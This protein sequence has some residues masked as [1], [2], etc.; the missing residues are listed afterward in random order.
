VAREVGMRVLT[1]GRVVDV[2]DDGRAP[3]FLCNWLVR[4]L[5]N[6]PEPDSIDDMY[7]YVD[8]G[9]RVRSLDGSLDH[10]SCDAGHTRHSYGTLENERDN[11]AA[12][13]ETL[14]D[15]GFHAD[16]ARMARATGYVG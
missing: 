1:N 15:E 13:I 5:S 2:A 9:A 11:I 3:F 7:L 6:N 10:L 8:C 12:E 4:V 14:R 16:A